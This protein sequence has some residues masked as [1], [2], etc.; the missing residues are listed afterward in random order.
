LD[1]VKHI[2]KEVKDKKNSFERV[3]LKNE[4]HKLIGDK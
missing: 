1:S 3:C 2:M 4:S